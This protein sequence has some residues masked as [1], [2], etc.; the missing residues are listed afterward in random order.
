ME[1]PCD[2]YNKE[3]VLLWVAGSIVKNNSQADKLAREGYRTELQEWVTHK[4]G[5]KVANGD[6]TVS[7]KRSYVYKTVVDA[8]LEIQLPVN[9]IFDVFKTDSF[10][11]QKRN[12]TPQIEAAVDVIMDIC[13]HHEEEAVGTMHLFR[14]GKFIILNA[15]YNAIMTVIICKSVGVKEKYQRT[16]AAAA[17]TSNAS[18]V[19]LMD[20]LCSQKTPMTTEQEQEYKA[21][22]ENSVMLLTR[23]GVRDNIWLDSVYMHHELLNGSGFPRGVKDSDVPVGARIL[24]IAEAYVNLILPKQ[25]MQQAPAPSKALV[26]LFKKNLK[27]YDKKIMSKAISRLTALPP[28]TFVS[29][30]DGGVGVVTGVD[31]KLEKPI[32][33]KVGDN[34]SRFYSAFPLTARLAIADVIPPPIQVPKKLLR[35]WA[36]AENLQQTQ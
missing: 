14:E 1:L 26:M 27:V 25:I 22:P 21:H 12:L 34:I 17:L 8:I 33:T 6:A 29:L 15:I 18:V 5:S 20:T 19:K 30:K 11:K 28:G 35:L 23:A 9:Y 10:F 13:A 3:G 7:S 16:L 31:R 2:I 24:V 4:T 32:V 36:A